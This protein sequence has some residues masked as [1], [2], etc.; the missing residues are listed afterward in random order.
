MSCERELGVSTAVIQNAVANNRE[1]IVNV[2]AFD[3]GVVLS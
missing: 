2:I 1:F 3:Q